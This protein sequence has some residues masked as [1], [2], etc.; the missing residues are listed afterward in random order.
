MKPKELIK[1]QKK[2]LK[3]FKKLKETEEYKLI[4]GDYLNSSLKYY[5]QTLT[6]SIM[7]GVIT[8]ADKENYKRIQL[9]L[10]K[11]LSVQEFLRDLGESEQSLIKFIE[12]VYDEENISE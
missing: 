4:F 12:E 2:L 7:S 1:K 3:A 8:D 9:K 6:S 11:Y 5:T 10:Q